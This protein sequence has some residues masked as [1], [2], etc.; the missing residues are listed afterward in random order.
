MN[1]FLRLTKVADV[2]CMSRSTVYL[3]VKQGLMT[4][5]VKLSTR[6]SVWPEQEIATIKTAHIAQKS[7][8]EIRRLVILL[9]Q[10]RRDLM[11]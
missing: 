7:A 9:K 5:P 11:A 1:D 2:M 4:P 3:R 6:C 8:D 10:Q